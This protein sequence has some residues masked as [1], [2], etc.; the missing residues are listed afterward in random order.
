MFLVTINMRFKKCIKTLH[1]NETNLLT[2][3]DVASWMLIR[4]ANLT[5]ERRERWIAASPDEQFGINDVQHV[6][7]RLFPQLH[8]N[9]HRESDGHFPTAEERARWTL[10]SVSECPRPLCS[11]VW[12]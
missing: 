12:S 7:V 2:I 10:V 4:K 6:L 5:Q 1:D 11:R 8:F 3:D 9:E